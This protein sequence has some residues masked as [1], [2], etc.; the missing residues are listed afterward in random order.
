MFAVLIVVF[1][2]SVLGSAHCGVMCGP[3]AVGFITKKADRRIYFFSR[4]LSY[5]GVTLFA[6]SLSDSFFKILKLQLPFAVGISVFAA[7]ILGM[8]FYWA[9]TGGLPR[10]VSRFLH[11]QVQSR[12][13]QG[14]GPFVLGLA[15]GILPCGWFYTF[16][17]AALSYPTLGHA[18]ALISAF[19]LGT[20]PVFTFLSQ[21][22]QRLRKNQPG[23]TASALESP[24]F[25][26]LGVASFFTLGLL[27]KTQILPAPHL[28]PDSLQSI[29]EW[30]SYSDGAD[31]TRPSGVAP[32]RRISPEQVDLICRPEH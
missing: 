26:F 22:M 29:W 30:V 5:A 4:W 27:W 12:W 24:S 1:F 10:A 21:G 7:L 31:A 18:L 6:Y 25:R 19:W 17:L 8:A 15:S 16:V 13:V 32:T 14:A 9:K 23:V 28:L 2:I 11:S 3:L 20:L